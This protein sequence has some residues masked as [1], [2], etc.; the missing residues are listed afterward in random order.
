MKVSEHEVREGFYYAREHEWVKVEG[1]LVRVGIT[2]Y[3]QSKLGDVVYVEFPPV[4]KHV[5][6]FKEPRSRD[7]EL[8]AVESVKAVST[9]YNPISGTVKEV[10]ASIQERP[11]II[12]NSPYDKGWICVISP[13]NLKE[14]LKSLMDAKA[15]SEYLKKLE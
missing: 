9:I 7:M 14:E 2:D 13:E 3:A 8:G 10:N 11:E 15:Y 12:N 1:E 6:Q 4:G 5:K